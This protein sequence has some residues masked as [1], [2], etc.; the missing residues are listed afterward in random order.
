MQIKLTRPFTALVLLALAIFNVQFSTLHAQGTAFTYSGQLQSNGSPAANGLYD[1]QFAL[2]N[3]PSGGSQIGSGFTITVGVTNGLF[4][5]TLDFGAVFT[6]TATWLAI[7]VRPSGV[8]NYA[9]LTPLQE[10]TPT[11]YA[12]YAENSSNLSGTVSASQ[13]SSIGNNNGGTGNYFVGP[14][15][16]ST[17]SGSINTADGV[18]ALVNNEGGS[19]NTANGYQALS[20][21][22]TGSGNTAGGTFALTANTTGNDNTAIGWGT[23]FVNTTGGANSAYGVYALSQNSTGSFNTAGGFESLYGNTIGGNNTAGGYEALYGN[24][25]GSNNTANGYEALDENTTGGNNTASGFEALF[26]NL[27]GTTNAAIGEQALYHNRGGSLNT[28]GGVQSLF[29]N[30]SGSNN[31]AL[32]YAAGY[33]ITTGSS[34]IDIG[35]PG[36][37]TDTNIIRIGDNQG[38][39]FLA[40]VITNSGTLAMQAGGDMDLAGDDN[41]NITTEGLMILEA[42]L[43]KLNAPTFINQTLVVEGLTTLAGGVTAGSL[44]AGQSSMSG[45]TDS[46]N[47]TVSGSVSI[48]NNST[49]HLLVVGSANSPAYCDGTT[50]V[51]ASDRNSKE[52][53][54]V[55]DPRTVLEKISALPITEWKYKAEANGTEHIGPMAQDFHAA[56]GLNGPDDKHISTVDEGGVALA[57]IQGLNQKLQEDLDRQEAENAKLKQQND[58]LADRLS[59]IEST[60]KQL[61][62]LK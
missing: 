12:I 40:G 26:S 15:G 55:I 10:L 48:G 30:T 9:N 45:L 21:N 31:I 20:A 62:T 23:M 43:L 24:T 37:A 13:L 4:T 2:S 46:G 18:G 42:P 7:S 53:F 6:G 58:L 60:V 35:N 57:A 44:I 36:L 14:S 16:N 22:T 3:A 17:T 32:G 59:E 61:A 27:N 50:W 11:P 41:V 1:F 28:A 19:Q 33:N 47:L 8:G 51:N 52:G 56:F 34:N 29:N 39:I 49:A 5:T 25:T 38:E 54:A